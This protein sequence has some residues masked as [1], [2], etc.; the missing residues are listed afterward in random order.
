MTHALAETQV[1]FSLHA[2]MEKYTV[3]M[4]HL[5]VIDRSYSLAM[6]SGHLILV[7]Q[8]GVK[9]VEWIGGWEERSNR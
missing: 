5:M 4:R 7:L 6:C 3:D 8:Y 9:K 1:P 2:P